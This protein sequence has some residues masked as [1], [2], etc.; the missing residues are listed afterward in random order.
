MITN[1]I[2]NL[3]LLLFCTAPASIGGTSPPTN[4]DEPTYIALKSKKIR[5]KDN[6]HDAVPI[7]YYADGILTVV[8]HSN[9]G[10]AA[11]LIESHSQNS[12]INSTCFSPGCFSQYIGTAKGSYHISISTSLGNNYVGD[13]IL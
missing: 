5:P 2:V 1:L 6:S 12:A 3:L 9:E 10:K 7:C 13:F 11:I 8:F 4:T